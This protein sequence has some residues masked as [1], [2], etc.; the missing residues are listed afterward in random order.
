MKNNRLF[1]LLLTFAFAPYSVAA[2]TH[3]VSQ[4][5]SSIIFMWDNSGDERSYNCNV[6][7]NYAYEDYG[8]TKTGVFD[9][10]IGIPAK[11][12]SYP[13]IALP[14]LGVNLH[15][16]DSGGPSVNCIPSSSPP[17]IVAPSAPS[18]AQQQPAAP[19]QKSQPRI[20]AK[21]PCKPYS[22]VKRLRMGETLTTCEDESDPVRQNGRIKPAPPPGVFDSEPSED[23]DSPPPP[24]P[25]TDEQLKR[26]LKE[27]S[28]SPLK[29][30]M[31]ECIVPHQITFSSE[32][33]LR[34]EYTNNCS[35]A[36]FSAKP[37]VLVKYR[38]VG[39]P[40]TYIGSRVRFKSLGYSSNKSKIELHD[41]IFPMWIKLND[42]TD[43]KSCTEY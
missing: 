33:T 10:P 8:E 5:G 18:A 12:Q 13:W 17:A 26:K 6:R 7:F 2:P 36:C 1:V 19:P 40:E 34:V 29:N 39:Y 25:L 22:G 41:S 3:T 32:G 28:N 15:I 4:P 14:A 21:P 16:T 24:P 27:D 42:W 38:E 9:R 35:D 11:A 37:Y 31:L 43:V 23:H 30:K 20:E